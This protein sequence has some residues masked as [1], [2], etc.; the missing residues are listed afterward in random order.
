MVSRKRSNSVWTSE[1]SSSPFSG[2]E[3]FEQDV[4]GPVEAQR[5]VD[6]FRA[7]LVS[8][9][10]VLLV[11]GQRLLDHSGEEEKYLKSVLHDFRAGLENL[12]TGVLRDGK[13]LHEFPRIWV[14]ALSKADLLPDYDVF[15]FRD[16]LVLKAALRGSW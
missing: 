11:D 7:L 5:R 10:A 13:L 1:R 8:D 15:K 2:G 14:L 12:K 16:L 9:V 4:S 6:T 3:W